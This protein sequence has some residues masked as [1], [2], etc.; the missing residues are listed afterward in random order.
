MPAIPVLWEA[1]AGDSQ[2]Q[3][4]LGQLSDKPVSKF[5]RRLEMELSAMTLG[6]TPI[7]RSFHN[8]SVQDHKAIL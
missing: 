5:K 4:Q 3:A 2:F 7:T 8:Q 1:E 6:S